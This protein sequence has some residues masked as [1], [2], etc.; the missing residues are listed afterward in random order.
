MV[1]IPRTLLIIYVKN[2]GKLFWG[3]VFVPTRVQSTEYSIG[4]AHYTVL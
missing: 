4:I 3:P 1:Q 2:E